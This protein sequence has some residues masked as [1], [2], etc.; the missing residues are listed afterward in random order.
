MICSRSCNQW[1]YKLS[2]LSFS[3]VF[4]FFHHTTTSLSSGGGRK[5]LPKEKYPLGTCSSVFLNRPRWALTV[6]C[7]QVPILKNIQHSWSLPLAPSETVFREK[8]P[9]HFSKPIPTTFFVFVFVIVSKEKKKK[10]YKTLSWSNE[11]L[12]LSRK[13]RIRI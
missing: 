10:N 13:V 4:L 8:V 7:Q 11:N 1:D 9:L 3:L 2:F 6:L 12:G 5:F